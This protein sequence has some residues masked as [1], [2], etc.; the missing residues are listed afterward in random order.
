MPVARIM[1]LRTARLQD[2]RSVSAGVQGCIRSGRQ[3]CLSGPVSSPVQWAPPPNTPSQ[4]STSK[5]EVLVAGWGWYWDRERRGRLGRQALTLA[6]LAVLVASH[7]VHA[8]AGGAVGGRAVRLRGG[9]AVSRL[10]GVRPLAAAGCDGGGGVQAAVQRRDGEVSLGLRRHRAGV[11]QDAHH[12]WGESVRAGQ[13]GQACG[14][15]GGP[16]RGKKGAGAMPGR[17][18]AGLG[19]TFAGVSPLRALQPA[20]LR[21]RGLLAFVGKMV[22]GLSG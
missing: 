17:C 3:F 9:Q 5:W 4:F 11:A 19:Q 12:L 16:C 8:V 22:G 7:G 20:I 13:A 2:K 14:A 18:R 10:D 15:P 21:L 6:V 1:F